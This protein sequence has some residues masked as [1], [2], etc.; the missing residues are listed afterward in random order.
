M[1][2]ATYTS[3][4]EY[5][6]GIAQTGSTSIT[7][8]ADAEIVV[9]AVHGWNSYNNIFTG[10]SVSVGG[11]ACALEVAGDGN[12]GYFMGALFVG[13][14]RG[15][16][17]TQTL[18]WA[19]TNELN[20]PARVVYG[21]YKGVDL[22]DFPASAYRSTGASQGGS[23]PTYATATLDAEPG[24]LVVAWSWG[25]NGTTAAPT[26]WTNATTVSNFNQSYGNAVGS[27]AEGDPSVDVAVTCEWG[28]ED[29]ADGGI[30]A[31]V[32]K[33]A[34]GAGPNEGFGVATL[35]L[36]AS[37]V[38][39]A[40]ASGAGAVALTLAVEGA[41]QH[42]AS[43][44]GAPALTLGVSGGGAHVASGA[45]TPALTLSAQGVGAA[46]AYGDG[47]PALTLGAA[48]TG[49]APTVG[50][51]EGYGSIALTLGTEGVGAH[52][53][54]GSGTPALSL[55][56]AGAGESDRYGSGALA[57]ALGASGYGL[58]PNQPVYV[59]VTREA[60]TAASAS[61]EAFRAAG[62]TGESLAVSG[63]VTGET[64]N[65]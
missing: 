8:P 22:S 32:L 17:G 29:V 12:T 40:S 57:L 34:A 63:T 11:R 23:P 59:V 18:A 65:P 62:P 44:S 26:G 53:A 61:A 45:G 38:G 56:V 35:T 27:W 15:L 13:D 49:D 25:Y 19:W 39:R 10:G 46:A 20:N 48:G 58:I 41:G 5:Q 55:A 3:P 28:V 7:V 52:T 37:G 6:A 14:V 1:G 33:P 36:G 50:A 24:D 60:F 2:S 9:V 51:A 47:T 54:A 30:C 21:F 42:L 64:F 43:G 31:L 16:T 4:T